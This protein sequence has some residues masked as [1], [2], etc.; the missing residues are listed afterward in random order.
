MS[1]GLLKHQQGSIELGDEV[2]HAFDTVKSEVLCV[3]L[4]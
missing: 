4:H 1:H 3:F 2:A